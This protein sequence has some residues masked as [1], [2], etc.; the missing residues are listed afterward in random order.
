MASNV[1]LAEDLQS[2]RAHE[3]ILLAECR[4]IALQAMHS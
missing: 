3:F 4:S 1:Y 2:F